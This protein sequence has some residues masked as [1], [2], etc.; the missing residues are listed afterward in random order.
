MWVWS[1]L[2]FLFSFRF[3]WT[4]G[5]A[6]KCGED[7]VGRYP[8]GRLSSST[9]GNGSRKKLTDESYDSISET[10]ALCFWAL[11]I[12]S[13][14]LPWGRMLHIWSII[15]STAHVGHRKWHHACYTLIT[16]K[17]RPLAVINSV[18]EDLE[19]SVQQP[20]QSK[21]VILPLLQL[22]RISLQPEKLVNVMM[23]WF[24]VWV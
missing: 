14:W 16:Q 1:E 24:C 8:E 17:I 18:N 20:G 21:K 7:Q 2:S 6:G 3:Q 13:D 19:H 10:K 15:N 12:G 4:G 23:S 22:N 11:Y 9:V 5:Q